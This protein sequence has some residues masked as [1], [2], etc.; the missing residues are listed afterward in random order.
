MK[1][2]SKFFKMLN[3]LFRRL[4]ERRRDRKN[5][6]PE[7]KISDN[8]E[9][10]YDKVKK[11]SLKNSSAYDNNGLIVKSTYGKSLAL[12]FEQ[13]F[14]SNPPLGTLGIITTIAGFIIFGV[15][16]SIPIGCVG[17]AVLASVFPSLY[18]LIFPGAHYLKNAKSVSQRLNMIGNSGNDSAALIVQHF[19][20]IISKYRDQ[21]IGPGTAFFDI[22]EQTTSLGSQ[23]HQ[24]KEYWEKR[25]FNLDDEHER[26][27][28]R[29]RA[30]D[31][32]EIE[33]RL[34]QV[35]VKL[36]QRQQAL[37]KH[38]NE[39][40][41][42]L[43]R[44]ESSVADYFEAKNL[45]ELK[46]RVGMLETAADNACLTLVNGYLTDLQQLL[47]SA[48]N[49]N[50]ITHKALIHEHPLNL[51]LLENMAQEIEDGRSDAEGTKEKVLQLV[52]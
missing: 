26:D 27:F 1:S 17:G 19:K 2:V 33:N 16:I 29:R 3:R 39:A 49:L 40:E 30:Q 10:I 20:S 23:A 22:I 24:Q 5:P 38:F 42:R 41:N 25:A 4:G 43:P 32:I 15:N 6:L 34:E 28:A 9:K 11:D 51:P 7:I 48:S 37:A 14:F 36:R 35:L 8:I 21:T 50:V 45:E 31:A 12:T 44:I 52:Q 18:L 46:R 47:Q 13:Y